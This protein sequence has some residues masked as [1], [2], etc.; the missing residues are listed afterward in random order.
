SDRGWADPAVRAASRRPR[1]LPGRLALDSNED[2][3]P[4]EQ[5]TTARRAVTPDLAGNQP[6]IN[7][8]HLHATQLRNFALRQ[9]LV[10]RGAV[11]PH[12]PP[13]FSTRA[14]RTRT[15]PRGPPAEHEVAASQEPSRV[16]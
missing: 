4:A 11:I 9:K 7:G 2:V 1:G 12:I 13:P 14:R 10:A 8:T 15:A 6:S 3:A 5:Q 16:S